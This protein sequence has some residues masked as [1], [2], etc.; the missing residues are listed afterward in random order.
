M[1]LKEFIKIMKIVDKNHTYSL[2]GGYHPHLGGISPT[3]GGD[4]TH[5]WGGYHPQ[6]GNDKTC[7]IKAL[8]P[9]KIALNSLNYKAISTLKTYLN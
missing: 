2:G 9:I 7:K 3:F 1:V 6:G 4:I 8:R 5:I